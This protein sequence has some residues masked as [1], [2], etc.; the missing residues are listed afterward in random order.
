MSS[1]EFPTIVGIDPGSHCAGF[2]VIRSTVE[3][4]V[5]PK[6]F[7]VID[8]GVFRF[9]RTLPHSERISELHHQLYELLTVNSSS[10]CVIE[11]AFCGVNVNSA[12]KLGE[13]RGALIAAVGR[14]DAQLIEMTPSKIKKS[15]AGNGRASKDE[16][17]L[18]LKMLLS[19]DRGSLPY[20]VTDALA[21]ALSYGL[22]LP[23]IQRTSVN[24]MASANLR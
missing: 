9:D 10:V 12:L 24:P 19:F 7:Q 3:H 23:L 14:A 21:M 2:A 18:A 4:P 1:S 16:V 11:K 22:A 15:I 6:H 17:S 5:L 8:A 13:A 20:D